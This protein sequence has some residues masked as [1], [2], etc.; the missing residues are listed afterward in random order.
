[1]CDDPTK[2]TGVCFCCSFQL[3]NKQSINLITSLCWSYFSKTKLPGYT[4][5][6]LSPKYPSFPRSVTGYRDHSPSRQNEP[7]TTTRAR[8][9]HSGNNS[10]NTT[11][12][13][14]RTWMPCLQYH[15]Y[16]APV[17]YRIRIKVPHGTVCT[18]R[19]R[20]DRP[21]VDQQVVPHRLVTHSNLSLHPVL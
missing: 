21:T 6:T 1:V 4:Y 9:Q 14:V 12:V 2:N 16:R 8:Q 13:V 19:T 7:L 18:R 17:H 20:M 5:Y 10:S 15:L 11:P 3:N